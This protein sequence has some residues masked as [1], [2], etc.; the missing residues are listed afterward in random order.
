M[1]K[2]FGIQKRLVGSYFIVIFITVFILEVLLITAVRYYYVNNVERILANQAEISASF[3]H[4]YFADENIVEQSE[5]L[6]KGFA[7]NTTAQVQ[8][9]D[10]RGMLLQDSSEGSYKLLT[11]LQFPDLGKAQYGEAG[12]WKGRDPL[13]NELVMAV[14][15]PLQ[16]KQTTVGVVRFITSLTETMAT[17]R[18]ITT[19]LISVGLIVIV[20]VAGLGVVLSRM[21]TS[22]IRDLKLAAD[23]MAEGDFTVRAKKRYADELGTLAD[24]LN[25]MAVKIT[26]NE[27]LKNDFISSVSHEIRTPLTSIKGWVVTLKPDNTKCQQLLTEGLDI[28][29]SETDRLTQLVDE[30]LDLSKLDNGRIELTRA[31]VHLSALLSHI[32]AQLAPRAARLGI[33]LEVKADQNQEM[34]L[35][36]ENRLKQVLI[37]LL[38]NALKFTE[39]EGHIQI[40]T[41]SSL[42]QI[43]ITIE[44]SGVG[45]DPQDIDHVLNK[46]YKG[47]HKR[48]GSGL[49]L[50]ICAEI[51]KLHQGE[52][53]IDSIPGHGTKVHIC[54]PRSNSK[55]FNDFI[56]F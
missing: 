28:I 20:I 19:M 35:A 30:L 33:L 47:T 31:P 34:I 29:E 23:R 41:H 6:L 45:I 27:Q 38:D 26:R 11:R 40:Y 7:E 32:S 49:G 5:R 37:N 22:S 16:A 15:Y 50:S 10:S 53:L 9:I 1:I 56:T 13:T 43:V 21:I 44:D 2:H 55:N 25:T 36:D 4:H 18:Y 14:S 42:E 3:F 54:L 12:V 46:F 48:A 52:L 8:I 39:A 24:T 17:I 51:I